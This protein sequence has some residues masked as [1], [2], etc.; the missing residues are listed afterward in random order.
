MN[1][2]VMLLTI[3]TQNAQQN[4]FESE[5]SIAAG[6]ILGLVR[7]VGDDDN[8]RSRCQQHP[9]H[10]GGRPECDRNVQENVK[11]KTIG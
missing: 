4:R 2:T 7:G 10:R 5:A 11:H 3:F 8:D 6:R 1:I 9:Q